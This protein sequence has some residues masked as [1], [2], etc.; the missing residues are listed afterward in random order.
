M[1]HFRLLNLVLSIMLLVGCTWTGDV[2][3]DYIS[4]QVT[5]AN[6][7]ASQ[8]LHID[9]NGYVVRT[10][11][12][13]TDEFLLSSSDFATLLNQLDAIPFA[14][15]TMPTA[16]ELTQQQYYTITYQKQQIVVLDNA[17]PPA[18]VP[19]IITFQRIMSVTITE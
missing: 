6:Q 8:R 11:D 1:T 15:Y 7:T 5:P 2:P 4:F 3:P 16:L 19:L 17:V 10:A 18:I 13:R 12:R 14:R 9:A